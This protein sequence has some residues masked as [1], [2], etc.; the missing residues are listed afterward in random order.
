MQW[1]AASIKSTTPKF[2][3]QYVVS[4]CSATVRGVI[5]IDRRGKPFILRFT[6]EVEQDIPNR[7][8]IC[9]M[10]YVLPA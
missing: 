10:V 3:P 9:A 5:E 7:S 6:V 1:V 4:I 2:L 8:A